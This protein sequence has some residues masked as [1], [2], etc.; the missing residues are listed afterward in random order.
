MGVKISELTSMGTLAGTEKLAGVDTGT[1]YTTP[2]DLKIYLDAYHSPMKP[3]CEWR[4][5]THAGYGSTDTKIPYFTNVRVNVDTASAITVTNNSTN[6]C[7]VLINTADY[8]TFSYNAS[9]A[10]AT[11]IGF[12][13]NSAQLTTGVDAINV[14]N[15]LALSYIVGTETA[16]VSVRL[17]CAVNDVVRPHTNAVAA[18]T[19][20]FSNFSVTRG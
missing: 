7:M 13:L 14:Q 6:G 9:P 18:D 11:Y 17:W 4:A 8:Y 3:Q 1:Q 16:R 5:D 20:A 10:S 15:R 2:A 19:A 12:S